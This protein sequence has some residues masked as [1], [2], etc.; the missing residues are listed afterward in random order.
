MEK[1][2]QA[3]MGVNSISVTE[4]PQKKRG[5][6][7]LLGEKLDK[8]VQAYLTSFRESGA[9]AMAC[10]EGIVRSAD[11]LSACVN[12]GHILITKDWANNVLH[13]MGFV[14]CRASTKAKVTVEEFELKKKLFLLHIKAVVTLEDIPSDLVMNWDQ[15]SM[16]VLCSCFILDES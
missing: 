8:Q 1:C 11:S 3:V 9:I 5:C 12:G 2:L 16:H 10:A 7:L 6:P 14:K 13:R 15:T 4:H